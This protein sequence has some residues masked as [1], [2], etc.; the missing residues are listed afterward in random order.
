MNMICQGDSLTMGIFLI[1]AGD[2]D[3]GTVSR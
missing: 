3:N 1:F 2:A